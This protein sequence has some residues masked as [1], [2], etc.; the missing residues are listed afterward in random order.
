[1]FSLEIVRETSQ[2]TMKNLV[3]YFEEKTI[4]FSDTSLPRLG[5][6]MSIAM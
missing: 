3:Q 6:T 4:I 5:K 1:M 2:T